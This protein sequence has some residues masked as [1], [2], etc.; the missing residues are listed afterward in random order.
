[1]SFV[2]RPG[3]FL[4]FFPTFYNRHSCWPLVRQTGSVCWSIDFYIEERFSLRLGQAGKTFPALVV[5]SNFEQYMIPTGT[6][7]YWGS[8]GVGNG[9]ARDR[10]CV[11]NNIVY[12]GFDT[13]I[14]AK[15][16]QCGLVMP[17]DE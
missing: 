13:I 3:D 14:A 4:Y 5:L 12:P 17:G 10:I 6:K 15:M 1:V 8:V 7:G 11:H 2:K 16:Q 9:G